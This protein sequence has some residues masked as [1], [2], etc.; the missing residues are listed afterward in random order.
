MAGADYMIALKKNQH[1]LAAEVEN[2]F[3]Q[4]ILAPEY[5]P[6]TGC[7]IWNDTHGR[8]DKQEVWVSHDVDWLPQIDEWVDLK[9]IV[10]IFRRWEKQGVFHEEKRYYIA[11]LN[12]SAERA[13][14]L[15]RRHWSIENEFHWHLDVTF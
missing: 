13:S 7:G 11:S 1:T 14:Q 9:S 3:D 2:F 4:A 10:M 15:A 5:A 8:D 6:C 12:P